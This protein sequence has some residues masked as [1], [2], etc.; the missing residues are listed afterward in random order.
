MRCD[1]DQGLTTWSDAAL[2]WTRGRIV[3][4]GIKNDEIEQVWID[5]DERKAIE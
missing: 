1:I 4:I 2:K 5:Q 3:S